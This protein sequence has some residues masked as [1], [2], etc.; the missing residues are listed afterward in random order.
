MDEMV[1]LFQVT[2]F[3]SP[4]EVTSGPDEGIYLHGLMLEGA[5]FDHQKNCLVESKLGSLSSPLPVLHVR[6]I[7]RSEAAA[8]KRSM[9]ELY[10]AP[11]Y[12]CGQRSEKYLITVVDLPTGEKSK[13]H[14]IL[15]GVSL[16]ASS[17]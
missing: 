2:S 14:W 10:E 3:S 13:S 15:R 17:S 1:F 11:L 4:E 9:G 12:M 6:A 8:K 7:R 5:S 16:L